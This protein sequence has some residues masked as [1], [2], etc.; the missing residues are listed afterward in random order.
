MELLASSVSGASIVSGRRAGDRLWE[1]GHSPGRGLQMDETAVTT[2]FKGYTK[3]QVMELLEIGKT[4]Y[5]KLCNVGLLEF[6]RLY[7]GGPRR[8]TPEQLAKYFQ[9]LNSGGVVHVVS[10]ESEFEERRR[11]RRFGSQ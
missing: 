5:H 7:P 11:R 9:Y 6:S 4:T 10:S 3:Y 1:G 2:E 8:H